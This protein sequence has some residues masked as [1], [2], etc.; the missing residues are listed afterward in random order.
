MPAFDSDSQCYPRVQ[1]TAVI[2]KKQWSQQW[3]N[4]TWNPES[5][6]EIGICLSLMI[7]QPLQHDWALFFTNENKMQLE[8]NLCINQK[9]TVVL[10]YGEGVRAW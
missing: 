3:L 9:H 2:L 4:P 5:F 6:Y 7:L 10:I 1:L 8:L